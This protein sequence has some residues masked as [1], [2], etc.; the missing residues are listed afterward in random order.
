MLVAIAGIDDIDEVR[1][2]QTDSD[3]PM[4]GFENA[5]MNMQRAVETPASN[6]RFVST[7]N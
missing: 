4:T 5:M 2:T 6:S 3:S 7:T 1:E